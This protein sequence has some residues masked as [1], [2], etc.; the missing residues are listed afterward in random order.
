[1]W[2]QTA[3]GRH[4]PPTHWNKHPAVSA[5]V[6]NDHLG[7]AIGY[8]SKGAVRKYYP[9]FI[10]RLTNGNFLILR[11]MFDCIII[12]TLVRADIKAFICLLSSSTFLENEQTIGN[13][14]TTCLTR[15]LEKGKLLWLHPSL[16][17][18]S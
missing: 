6:K 18:L 9:D 1:M 5:Y 3:H 17:S 12:S 7:F 4:Q 8:N 11:K 13:I 15:R 14:S 16:K 2:W 10:I